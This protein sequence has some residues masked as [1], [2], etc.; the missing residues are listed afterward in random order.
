[1]AVEDR[2]QVV[3]EKVTYTLEGREVIEVRNPEYA[4]KIEQKWQL[5]EGVRF[6]TETGRFFQTVVPVGSEAEAAI[7]KDSG[8]GL[9]KWIKDRQ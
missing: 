8:P 6:D 7:P 1:M 2:S 4:K 3:G 9:S 5:K